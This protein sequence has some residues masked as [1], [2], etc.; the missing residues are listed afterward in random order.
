M[1]QEDIEIRFVQSS[2][3]KRL[4]M[5]IEHNHFS[6]VVP[7]MVPLKKAIGFIADLKGW[8]QKQSL[9]K[10]S[11]LYAKSAKQGVIPLWGSECRVVIA[12]APSCSYVIDPF[13]Q[14]L[15]LFLTP[16]LIDD[17]L[18]PIYAIQSIC[19]LEAKQF[20]KTIQHRYP[21]ELR[22]QIRSL[23]FKSLRSRWGSLNAKGDMSLNWHLV[24][25][26]PDVLE[27]VYVHE[28]AH[29]S[30]KSHGARFWQKV[31][32]LKVDYKDQERWLRRYGHDL[33]GWVDRT[34]VCLN[35]NR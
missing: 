33:M 8:L 10:I 23:R 13:E 15:R 4:R 7:K 35:H 17:P 6:V 20:I 29:V 21:E 16:D 12:Q 2:R 18:S 31:A 34:F 25:A 1:L 26:P 19:I 5:Q 27:Y 30:Y 3:A 11:P 32:R 9:N 28:L 22:T 24:L 14:Q